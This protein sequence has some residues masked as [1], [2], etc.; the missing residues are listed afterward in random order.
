M[1]G[2]RRTSLPRGSSARP[3]A[4]EQIVQ[5]LRLPQPGPDPAPPRPVPLS[6]LPRLPRETSMLYVIGR[7]DASG[8]ITNGPVISALRW[9]PGDRIDIS[10]VPG[11]AI[12]RPAAGGRLRIPPRPCI[13][14]PASARHFLGVA[15]S[16]DVLLAAA[17]EYRIVIVHTTRALDDMLVNF[18]TEIA[19]A[20]SPGDE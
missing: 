9:Q 15:S 13:I 18:Y 14:V 4:A 11:A 12:Y 16:D 19:T 2:H 20:A 8:R 3:T 5:A 17:P 6:R 1:Q 7:L 10:L